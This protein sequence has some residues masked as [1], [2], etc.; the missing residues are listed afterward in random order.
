MISPTTLTATSSFP[1]RPVSSSRASMARSTSALSSKRKAFSSA[2]ARPASFFTLVTPT[3]EPVLAGLTKYG[4]RSA[5]C[6]ARTALGLDEPPV[7]RHAD[8]H[9]LDAI[10][11][12]CLRD[13]ARG[14][15]RDF[16]LGASAA[17]EED[18]ADHG[19]LSAE[20]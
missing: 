5:L 7:T 14:E 8:G 12:R 15:D 3:D 10:L 11:R 1:S 20:C 17:E 16:V 6:P 13:G 2:V 4:S 9:D 18:G 19:V